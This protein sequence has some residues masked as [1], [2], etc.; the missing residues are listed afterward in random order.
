[1]DLVVSELWIYVTF[2][3]RLSWTVTIRR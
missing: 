3:D 2:A 1:M